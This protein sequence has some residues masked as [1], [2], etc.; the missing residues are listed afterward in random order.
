MTLPEHMEIAI[1]ISTKLTHAVVMQLPALQ[2]H[3]YK[4]GHS[5]GMSARILFRHGNIALGEA[6]IVVE[7]A[8]ENVSGDP[9]LLPLVP[10]PAGNLTL[11]RREDAPVTVPQQQ[12]QYPAT[13]AVPDQVPPTMV[14]R[15]TMPPP[16]YGQPV[17]QQTPAALGV[18]VGMPAAP[19][20]M[21]PQPMQP[22]QQ[23]VPANG[24]MP[25]QQGQIPEVPS[26]YAVG[27]DGQVRPIRLVRPNLGVDDSGITPANPLFAQTPA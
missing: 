13:Q 5:G 27:A 22:V 8:F 20:P 1:A 11:A 4:G 9:D 16:I 2:E 7:L 25:V 24:G 17:I 14:P 21:Q 6:A 18:P 3:L 26:G 12:A 15:Q 19:I 23:A 10:G